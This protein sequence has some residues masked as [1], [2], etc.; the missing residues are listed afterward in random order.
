MLFSASILGAPLGS[1]LVFPIL[2]LTFFD[3]AKGREDIWG[4]ISL[5]QVPADIRLVFTGDIMAHKKQIEIAEVHGTPENPYNFSPQFKHVAHLLKGDL[6]V[7]NFETVVK[8]T[9]PYQGYPSFNTPDSLAD[10][11]LAV[12][13]NVLLLANNHILDQGV[14]AGL[15]TDE[16]L[17]SKGFVTAGISQSKETNQW[18]IVEVKGYKIGII[19]GTYGSNWPLSSFKEPVFVPITTEMDIAADVK[20]L[21]QRGVDYIIAS[22]HWGPEYVKS[23]NSWQKAMAQECFDAGVDLVVGHHPHVLQPMEAISE[24]GKTQFV[25]WSLGNFISSQRTLPRERTVILAVDL[26]ST[27]GFSLQL[28]KV[29]AAPLYVDMQ[30]GVKAQLLPT[31]FGAM[32]LEENPS[33]PA[34]VDPGVFQEIRAS[35]T[36][37]NKLQNIHKEILSF[38]DLPTHSDANGFHTV[39]QKPNLFSPLVESQPTAP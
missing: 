32:S 5:R 36:L 9:G 15:R 4:N 18:P 7:G 25:A 34:G 23:P 6:V 21:R 37:Q 24:N 14:A 2:M 1:L 29:S 35:R 33:V 10:A 20:S 17:R 27:D 31:R 12:N 22:F 39:W 13:F 28:E 38:L 19:N 30:Y 3:Y 8:G 26:K 16:F 11:L